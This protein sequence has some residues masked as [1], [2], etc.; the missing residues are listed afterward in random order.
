VEGQ[1]VPLGGNL[2]GLRPDTTR[3]QTD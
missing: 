3:E 2:K 1:P